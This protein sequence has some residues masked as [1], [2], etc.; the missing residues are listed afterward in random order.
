MSKFLQTPDFFEAKFNEAAKL[1]GKH[2]LV[3][4]SYKGGVVFGKSFNPR[5]HKAL[6]WTWHIEDKPSIVLA[7]IGDFRDIVL[8]KDGLQKF[9]Q[10]INEIVGGHSLTAFA[11]AKFVAAY[12]SMYHDEPQCLAAEV[13]V[14]DVDTNNFFLVSFSGRIKQFTDFVV[15]GANTYRTPFTEE[16]IAEQQN[17]VHAHMHEGAQEIQLS[18]EMVEKIAA[19]VVEVRKP[20]IEFLKKELSRKSYAKRT[21]QEMHFLLQ[22][23]LGDFDPP[24]ESERFE[25]YFAQRKSPLVITVNRAVFRREVKQEEAEKSAENP[26]C[27]SCAKKA[28]Q[29]S[30]SKKKS[31]TRRRRKKPLKK[32]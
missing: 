6:Q 13:V 15:A 20:T 16:E 7:A 1:L 30:S 19:H 4:I 8:I 26:V 2:L 12:F 31:A 10:R 29:A 27:Q 22:M 17:L 5:S 11:V 28:A 3:G 23:A 14:T 24:S 25:V 9:V 21:P 32:K 18:P